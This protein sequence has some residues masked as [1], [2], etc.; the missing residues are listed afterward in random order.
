V[1]PNP[2]SER[3]RARNRRVEISLST[4]PRRDLW[5]HAVEKNRRLAKSLAWQTFRSSIVKLLG[6]TKSHPDEYAFAAAVARWQKRQPNLASDGIIGPNTLKRI[7]VVLRSSPPSPAHAEPPNTSFHA[8]ELDPGELRRLQREISSETGGAESFATDP[9]PILSKDG[10][11][12][13]TRKIAESFRELTSQNVDALVDGSR[14]P[15]KDP[16]TLGQQTD[17][18]QQRRHCLRGRLCQEVNAAL[19]DI[20]G[21][22]AKL[23]RDAFVDPNQPNFELLGEALHLIQD[24]YSPAH[25]EREQFMG[26][27]YLGAIKYVRVWNP[28]SPGFPTEHGYP[29]DA[30]DSLDLLT[31]TGVAAATASREFLKMAVDRIKT[32]GSPDNQVKFDAFVKKHLGLSSANQTIAAI[33]RLAL[34][35]FDPDPRYAAY[36]KCVVPNRP[37]RC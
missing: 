27:P 3:D 7:N 25:T 26:P 29:A 10:H 13:L 36:L 19:Q 33:I 8:L 14:R 20:R 35:P 32:P 17:E 24:S 37:K 9:I 22:L 31:A 18:C 4:Y 5:D 16:P 6:F 28:I 12:N 21:H 1:V 15:D 11:S 23:Y 34:T 2:S 30:R